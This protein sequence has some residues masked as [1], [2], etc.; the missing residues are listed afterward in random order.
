LS[1]ETKDSGRSVIQACRARWLC[2][3]IGRPIS[4]WLSYWDCTIPGYN[5]HRFGMMRYS[6]C[7]SPAAAAAAAA[8]HFHVA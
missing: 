6:F 3:N 5:A 8:R 4:A 7:A 2:G 1:Q